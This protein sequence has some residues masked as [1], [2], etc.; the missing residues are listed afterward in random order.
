VFN[1][2]ENSD[3]YNRVKRFVDAFFSRFDEFLQPGRHPKWKEVNLAADVPGWERVKPAQDWLD[4][5]V[6]ARNPS[7]QVQ[8]FEFFMNNRG[9]NVSAQER[10]V[11]F[12]EFLSWQGD[13]E[14]ALRR[15]TRQD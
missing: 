4:R 5:A 7:P 15:T 6:A 9:I 14:R 11:L 3:R 1:W 13:R 12:R 2:P 10:E 8:S